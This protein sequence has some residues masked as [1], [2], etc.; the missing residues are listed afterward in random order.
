[1]FLF[2]ASVGALVPRLGERL[3]LCAGAALSGAGFAAFAWLDGMH[4][5]ASPF[6]RRSSFL[7]AD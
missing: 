4:G 3:L 7:A 5:Y 1:M 2:S 6:C